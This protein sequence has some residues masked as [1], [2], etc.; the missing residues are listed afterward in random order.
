MNMKKILTLSLFSLMLGMSSQSFATMMFHNSGGHIFGG[1]EN[2]IRNFNIIVSILNS[3]S[4]NHSSKPNNK[5]HSDDKQEN[6]HGGDNNPPIPEHENPPISYNDDDM[7]NDH[8][9][10]KLPPYSGDNG[11]QESVPEPNTIFMLGFGLIAVFFVS[12]RKAIKDRIS[13]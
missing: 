4:I 12:R 6:N 9:N 2:D 11:K 7:N 1:S 8:E 10:E 13:A 5:S 3:H